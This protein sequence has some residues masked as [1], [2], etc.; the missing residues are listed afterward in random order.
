LLWYA[1]M[2]MTVPMVGAADVFGLPLS[3]I[4]SIVLL[5]VSEPTRHILSEISR[6]VTRLA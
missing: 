4:V 3:V 2:D 6:E 1:R 5:D